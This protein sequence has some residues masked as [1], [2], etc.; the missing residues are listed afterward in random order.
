MPCSSLLPTHNFLS[1]PFSNSPILNVSS[2]WGIASYRIQLNLIL[3]LHVRV[4]AFWWD[5]F[6]V[7]VKIYISNFFLALNCTF[8]CT[9]FSLFLT[10][11]KLIRFLFIFSFSTHKL[12]FS[13]CISI[14]LLITFLILTVILLF[15]WIS[16]NYI[17]SSNLLIPH[18]T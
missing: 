6:T 14:L 17:M 5:N 18:Q 15:L 13:L 2:Y 12:E 16:E 1:K 3:K 4:F 7:V 10:L 9:C 11:T 8:F